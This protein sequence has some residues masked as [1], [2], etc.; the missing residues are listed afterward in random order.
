M[1]QIMPKR[2]IIYVHG[3]DS[4]T[5][6]EDFLRYLKTTPIR[7]PLG[8]GTLRWPERLR[9]DLGDDFEVYMPTMPNKFN[10][11]YEEWV[12]WF[13]RYL[14]LVSDEVILIGWSLGGMFLAK[15]LSETTPKKTY[16]AVYLLAAPGGE[17]VDSTG[18]GG[19]CV[20]FR[21]RA[22]EVGKLGNSTKEL[23]IWHSEDD[24]VVPVT[25]ADWYA[26]MVPQAKI[27]IFKDKNHFLIES[28]P[29]LLAEIKKI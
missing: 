29:E 11:R 21:P 15:Y 26:R 17:F 9:K 5:Q 28:L 23:Y 18:S 24:F 25:E 8:M 2:Q 14:E 16:L 4:F 12:I 20:D 1:M 7:D 22:A 6:P 10:A 3:G 27:R 13:E 19:D